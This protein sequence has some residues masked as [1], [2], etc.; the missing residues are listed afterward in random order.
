MAENLRRP[1]AGLDPR[2]SISEPALAQ[3]ASIQCC[4]IIMHGIIVH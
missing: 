1:E 3:T 4:C 2:V